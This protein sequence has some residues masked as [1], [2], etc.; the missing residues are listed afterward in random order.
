MHR[1]EGR[2]ARGHQL[3]GGGRARFCLLV[4]KKAAHPDFRLLACRKLW[5]SKFYWVSCPVCGTVFRQLWSS[6][7]GTPV[8]FVQV[9]L[10]LFWG[11]SLIRS[12][13]WP[14]EVLGAVPRGEG[15]SEA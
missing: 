2:N 12:Q 15:P 8:P 4:P 13:M 5:E 11:S 7:H 3:L 6:S 1:G 9:L 10:S 14:K